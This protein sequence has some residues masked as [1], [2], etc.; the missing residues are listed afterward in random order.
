MALVTKL[1]QIELESKLLPFLF[2]ISSGVIEALWIIW[3]FTLGESEYQINCF[4]IIFN[5]I[6]WHK[7]PN[8]SNANFVFAFALE[9]WCERTF[10]TVRKRSLGQGNM[11]TGVCLS[12]G[13]VPG[14]GGCLLWG[15][16][17]SGG[18]CLVEKPPLDGY[19]C[20]RYASYWNVFLF[21]AVT[22]P[23]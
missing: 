17:C 21:A 12:T 11:F 10:I 2:L 23:S 6:Q 22:N 4:V 14:P 8:N 18:R 16:A 1:K 9:T 20:G 7:R 5:G 13:G 15:G 19:C 3:S